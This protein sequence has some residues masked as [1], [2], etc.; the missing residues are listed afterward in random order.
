[1]TDVC[2]IMVFA[3][4]RNFLWNWQSFY[5]SVE[6]HS[7]DALRDY[8]HGRIKEPGSCDCYNCQAK[9]YELEKHEEIWERKLLQ[10]L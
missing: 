3:I 1:M 2:Q 9:M 4:Q 8:T 5:L 10:L 6:G 7:C